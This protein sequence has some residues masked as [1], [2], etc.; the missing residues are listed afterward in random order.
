MTTA[1]M[2]S[3]SKSLAPSPTAPA[4]SRLWADTSVADRLFVL[5]QARFLLTANSEALADAIPAALRRT[6]ADSLAAEIL[7]LLAACQFLER[8]AARILKSRRLGKRGLPFWLAGT[9][10]IITRVPFG[11]ILVIGPSNYPLFLPGVQTL[12]ALAAGNTVVW[13]PGR[14]GEPVARLFASILGQAG[15]PP[16]ILRVTAE[17]IETAT[18]EI[19]SRP[20][21]IFF[22][23]SAHAG[24]QVL[25]LAADSAIPVVAELSGCDAVFVF[26]T[27]DSTRVIEALTFGMRLNGSATCMAPRRLILIAPEPAESRP[28]LDRTSIPA[29][30]LLHNLQQ[31]FATT[32]GIHLSPAT[33]VQLADL[34]DDAQSKGATILGDPTDDLLKPILIL[35]GTPEMRIAQS[36]IFAPIL[37]VLN[38]RTVDEAVAIHNICPM[39]LTAS[40]FGEQ[41]SATALSAQLKVG[42]VVINDL[43]VPTADPRIPFGGR[44]NS[45]F[46]V[47]RG[48]EGLLEMTAIKT[49]AIR[50]SK[51]RRHYQSTG[52]AHEKLFAGVVHMTH[53]ATLTQKFKGL[54]QLISAAKKLK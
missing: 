51:D 43:I 4:A 23:G 13:K 10:T 8:E 41:K 50:K 30:N 27:A 42:T 48:A 14:E 3:E 52:P 31:S 44:G 16:N 5:R 25:H 21:K 6:R 54:R 1:T 46:G 11:T 7:P 33:R 22:T 9:D 37:T 2:A 26:P 32:P 24:K 29:S 34:L 49:I 28:Q 19:Q 15:L 12:Q 17:S 18:T 38:A 47:T 35:N 36:D 20:A 53:S 40:I 45:G 39:G